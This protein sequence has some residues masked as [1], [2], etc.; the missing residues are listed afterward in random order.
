MCKL[1]DLDS[2][3]S[4]FIIRG[5]EVYYKHDLWQNIRTDCNYNLILTQYMHI[6]DCIHGKTKT[7][8]VLFTSHNI[9]QRFKTDLLY[10]KG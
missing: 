3:L 8:V 2:S 9:V 1:E 7:S 6:K 10:K 5:P 4:R